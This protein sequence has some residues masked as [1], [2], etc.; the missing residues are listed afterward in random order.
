[1][2]EPRRWLASMKMLIALLMSLGC[3][4]ASAMTFDEFLAAGGTKLEAENAKT[5][6]A[7]HSW[8]IKFGQ[9]VINFNA[10]GSYVGYLQPSGPGSARGVHGRWLVD[11][12]GQ[13]CG[14]AEWYGAT[15]EDP[16]KCWS[17]YS[18]ESR[19]YVRGDNSTMRIMMK[20]D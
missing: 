13:L 16:L 5:E 9:G 2:K 15:R 11:E 20:S 7:R 10:D 3:I 4:Q 18:L 6:I 8:Q 17:V 14:R 12:N 19:N 1:M